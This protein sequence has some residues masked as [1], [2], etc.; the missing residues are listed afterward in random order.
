MA[1]AAV[2]RICRITNSPK[3]LPSGNFI[4]RRRR[5]LRSDRSQRAAPTSPNFAIFEMLTESCCSS[6]CFY[7]PSLVYTVQYLYAYAA[8]YDYG[9]VRARRLGYN[10]PKSYVVLVLGNNNAVVGC[11]IIFRI[12]SKNNMC[13]RAFVLFVATA[14]HRPFE[15]RRSEKRNKL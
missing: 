11:N 3:T 10:R 13:R 5:G 8:L 9:A 4:P 6:R 2:Y 7:T 15:R 14:D 1:A 12:R